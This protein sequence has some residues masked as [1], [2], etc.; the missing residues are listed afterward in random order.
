MNKLS[1]AIILAAGSGKRLRPI[2]DEFPKC[3][4]EINGISILENSLQ[5]LSKH[6]IKETVIVIGYLGQKIIDRFSDHFGNMKLTYCRNQDY[7]TT[8]S[9]YSLWLAK[10]YLQKGAYL[11]EGDILFSEALFSEINKLSEDK[12]YWIGSQFE[13]SSE[14]S[15]SVSDV[16]GRIIEVE[17]VREKLEEYR[18][19]FLKSS[20]ILKLSSEYGVRLS[21]WLDQEVGLNNTN[22]YYDLV[23]SKHIN[24]MPLYAVYTE[25]NQWY[26]IDDINDLRKAE[27][28]F[29][30]RKYV[31]ILIDGG[32][33]IGIPE[34]GNKTAFEAANIPTIDSLTAHGR[35]GL[36]QTIYP[37]LPIGSVVANMG[38]LGYPP[39]RYYPSGR[40]SFEAISQN[41]FLD[42][43][44]IALRCNLI[45]LNPERS[46]KDFTANHIS[47]EM[48]LKIID[49]LI[50]NDSNIELYSGQSYRNICVVRDSDCLAEDIMA[51]EPHTNIGIKIDD[52]LMK[53]KSKRAEAL[54]NKLNSIMVDSISQLKEINKKYK[55]SADMLWFWSPS[56]NPKLPSFTKKYGIRGA[57]VAGLDFMR[58]IGVVA[59]M[60]TK[61]IHGATGYLDTNLKE[62]LKYCKNFLQHNDLVFVHINA[63]DEEAH[64]HNI[65]NKI[66]AIE[67]I[68]NE[69][70]SPLL[71]Y[72]NDRF[73]NNYKIALLPDHYTL[74][75]NG[76]HTD[77]PVPYLMYG[78]G[79]EK[80]NVQSFSEKA[81]AKNS[82]DILKSHNFMKIF[83]HSE[84][85]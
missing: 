1:N 7:E 27:R 31:I 84:G 19:N 36:M 34:I 25:S 77:D 20:G 14:G 59:G 22:I 85:V 42:A 68:E 78:A 79:I 38:I 52:I 73:P 48:A 83:L 54:V 12:S 23:I 13:P 28:L 55:T 56:S 24:E 72:L 29:Q 66:Y 15:M 10:D 63:A 16:D 37:G 9:M 45:S 3:M 49:N 6:G 44:D 39:S 21:L 69:F 71:K 26:E 65:K 11:I 43:R 60:E 74:V 76:Q 81:I 30:P 35:T 33:D 40:A 18:K 50:L 70:I 46:I 2:T 58:G 51:S 80:D 17:I 32:A 67:R 41:I 61:E 75:S 57:I 4:T 62:K 82:T 47:D 8:N 64:L 5:I 53:A